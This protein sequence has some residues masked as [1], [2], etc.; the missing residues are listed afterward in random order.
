[1]AI[2][3][4]QHKV[5]YQ[6]GDVMTLGEYVRSL[7]LGQRQAFRERL[8]ESHNCS[9]SLVRKW[10]AWPPEDGWSQAKRRQLVRR[11]PADLSAIKKTEELTKNVVTRHDLRP[12]CWAEEANDV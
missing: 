5:E 10:E 2:D 4:I 9:V 1:M 7:P 12:E 8:A 6:T 11:H 3:L